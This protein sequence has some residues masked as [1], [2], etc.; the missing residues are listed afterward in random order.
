[1]RWFD[2]AT[3]VGMIATD[4]IVSGEDVFF[5]F[6]AIPGQGYRTITPGSRVRF[7][8]VENASGPSARN[9]QLAG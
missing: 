8:V 6:T 1:M 2:A 9:I 4:A 7:E 3:G 5:H